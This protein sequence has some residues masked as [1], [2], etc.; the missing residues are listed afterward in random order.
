MVLGFIGHDVASS[1]TGAVWLVGGISDYQN[2][3]YA[4]MQMTDDSSSNYDASAFEQ[5]I[6]ASHESGHILSAT[7]NN[8]QIGGKYTVM[9]G[10]VAVDDSTFIDDFHSDSISL[11]NSAADNYL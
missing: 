9:A 3:A 2:F 4:V 5:K 8:N 6:N 7:H 10:N 11:I 1:T